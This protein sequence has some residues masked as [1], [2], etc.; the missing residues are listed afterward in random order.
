MHSS[1]DQAICI[2]H[3]SFQVAVKYALFNSIEPAGSKLHTLTLNLGCLCDNFSSDVCVVVRTHQNS[4]PICLPTDKGEEEG[5]G[6]GG[7]GIT[8]EIKVTDRDECKKN[9]FCGSCPLEFR[10]LGRNW[11]KIRSTATNH[12]IFILR[13]PS[14]GKIKLCGSVAKDI[15][16]STLYPASESRVAGSLS[17]PF[18]VLLLQFCS[19][20]SFLLE[21][22]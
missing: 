6:R 10:W 19:C 17:L 4:G 9:Q 21:F 12:I 18:S 16:L 2:S 1:D 22:L 13:P 5:E 14:P 8:D 20:S 11:S 15:S 3:P 7:E